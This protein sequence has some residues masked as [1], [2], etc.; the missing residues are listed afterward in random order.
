MKNIQSILELCSDVVQKVSIG[1]NTTE[2]ER[3]KWEELSSA[4]E[5]CA[6]RNLFQF[7]FQRLNGFTMVV[8]KLFRGLQAFFKLK[9]KLVGK[10]SMASFTSCKRVS[11]SF[12]CSNKWLSGK[13]FWNNYQSLENKVL[14]NDLATALLLL[15][16][17][18][19][20]QG[21]NCGLTTN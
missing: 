3:K 4:D 9:I 15:S 5:K 21:L 8:Y 16:H 14:Q 2:K 13:P 17:E 12:A 1:R 7:L 6:F 19:N 18:L 20:L 11:F 10:K